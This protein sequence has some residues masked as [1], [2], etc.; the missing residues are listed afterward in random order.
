MD[1]NI[2]YKSPKPIYYLVITLVSLITTQ[3]KIC[4]LFIYSKL[5]LSNHR[6]SPLTY[7]YGRDILHGPTRGNTPKKGN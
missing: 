6:I 5:L 1:Q 2:L 7:T 3:T 4:N